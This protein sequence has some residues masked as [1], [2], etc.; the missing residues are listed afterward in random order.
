MIS[1]M[2]AGAK[3]RASSA[4]QTR[5]RRFSRATLALEAQ[6]LRNARSSDFSSPPSACSA[7][8]FAIV[9]SENLLA[10]SSRS[11]RARP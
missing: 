9:S 1:E 11:I 6:S 7:S 2:S 4:L 3:P 10:K 8:T 5:C